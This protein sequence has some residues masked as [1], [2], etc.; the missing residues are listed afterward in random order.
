MRV[1]RC[2]R[3]TITS[4]RTRNASSIHIRYQMLEAGSA[5]ASSARALAPSDGRSNSVATTA[6][7][8]VESNELWWTAWLPF[9]LKP[10]IRTQS[11]LLYQNEDPISLV[12]LDW[13]KQLVVDARGGEFVSDVTTAPAGA[14]KAS[15]VNSP[16]AL[17]PRDWQS[18]LPTL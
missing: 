13:R 11:E 18:L 8:E 4:R 9:E 14:S 12:G 2:P 6:T 15:P 10:V 16:R 17:Q 3:L 5:K 7:V 1:M